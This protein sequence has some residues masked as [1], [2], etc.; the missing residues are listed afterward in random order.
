MHLS[1][2]NLAAAPDTVRSRYLFLDAR[3]GLSSAK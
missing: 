2:R 3:S 1:G